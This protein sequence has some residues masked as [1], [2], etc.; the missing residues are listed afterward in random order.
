M[1][2]CPEDANCAPPSSDS[3]IVV[4][5]C[6]IRILNDELVTA[7]PVPVAMTVHDIKLPPVNDQPI[8]ALLMVVSPDT[9]NVDVEYV[10]VKSK[11]VTVAE[12]TESDMISVSPTTDA[13][14]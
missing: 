6:E 4:T 12:S 14:R 9:E 2:P 13:C 3:A 11:F 5:G 8:P 10:A 1:F 7:T